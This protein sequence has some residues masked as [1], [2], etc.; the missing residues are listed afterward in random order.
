MIIVGRGLAW[1]R[2]PFSLKPFAFATWLLSKKKS[3][4]VPL[5]EKKK[6]EQVLEMKE[7]LVDDAIAVIFSNTK[8][9]LLEPRMRWN[10]F[11][12]FANQ[13][14][15]KSARSRCHSVCPF[16]IPLDYYKVLELATLKLLVNT[17]KD[18]TKD[19]ENAQK[20]TV[21]TRRP[22]MHVIR[23]DGTKQ[24]KKLLRDQLPETF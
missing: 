3:C 1:P 9:L 21:K 11:R 8:N 18:S 13:S 20:T 2:L 10:A 15:A 24:K 23:C 19:R 7:C 17:L 6:H 22:T 14:S 5:H 4:C 12:T 16:H